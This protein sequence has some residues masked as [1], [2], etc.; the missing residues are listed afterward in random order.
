M[1]SP[2]IELSIVPQLPCTDGVLVSQTLSGDESAFR[3]LYQRHAPYLAGVAC[4]LM[5]DTLEL[6]DVVQETFLVALARL[7]RLRDPTR[8]RRWLITVAARIARRKLMAR[9]RRRLLAMEVLDRELLTR[10]PEISKEVGNLYDA[11]GRLSAKLRLPWI[12]AKL[13]GCDMHEVGEAC[14][15][16]PSTAKRRVARADQSLRRKLG[17]PTGRRRRKSTFSKVHAEGFVHSAIKG[18]LSVIPP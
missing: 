8:I 17:I 13:E 11:L 10:N 15:I 14:G 1:A 18:W 9:K 5:G 7:G 4:R 2:V 16:S 12:L 3:L 6:D